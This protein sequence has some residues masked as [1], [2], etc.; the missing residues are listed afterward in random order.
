VSRSDR[1]PRPAW[2]RVSLKTNDNFREVGALVSDHSLHTV[3]Q[4]ARCPNVY[5]CWSERTATFMI[6]GDVCTR[7]CG[8]C[9]VRKGNPAPP[10]AEEPSRVAEV[11]EKMGLRYAVVTSVDRDDLAD[12]GAGHFAATIRAIRGR[13]PA[14]KVEVLTPDFDGRRELLEV[15]LDARPD[16]LGHN[17]ETVR[18]LYRRV[19]PLASYERSLGIL[20]ETVDFRRRTGLDVRAKCGIMVGL[21]E[22]MDEVVETLGDI[23]ATGCEIVTIGQYLSPTCRSLPV[24]RFYTPPEFEFL[25]ER[26]VSLGIAHAESAPLVRSSYHAHK[27]HAAAREAR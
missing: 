4:E 6:L 13:L 12:G 27:A 9:S 3:C 20:R 2:L 24:R 26:A 5:E 11:V 15:V 1:L 23:A 7:R 21:G 16:V 22:T 18:A 8:F 14:C 25:R 17:L 19:R 10:D